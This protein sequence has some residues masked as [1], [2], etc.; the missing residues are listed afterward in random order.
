MKVYG[1]T[2]F[3]TVACRY[4]CCGGPLRKAITSGH[5]K[6]EARKAAKKRARREAK[7]EAFL[8]ED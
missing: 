3:D 7:K 8:V 5:R 6:D 2:R 1:A 4:G